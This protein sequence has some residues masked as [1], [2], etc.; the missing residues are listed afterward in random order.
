MQLS[1]TTRLAFAVAAL[2]TVL[3]ACGVNPVTG[4]KE[5]QFVSEASELQIGEKNYSPTR[6]G[7]GG[8]LTVLPELTTY[9]SGV[10]Q[11][12][13]AV[14]DRKLPY[15]F[16]VLNNSV[17]NAWALPGGKIAVNRGLLTELQ[18]EAELAAVLGHEIVHAAA[19][20]GAKAQE[21]GTMMQIGM[22]AAQVGAAVGG[23]DPGIANL[24]LGGASTGLQMIQMKYG[25]D[26]ELESDLYGMKYMKLAGYDP[27]G[28][29]TLQETFVRLSGAGGQKQQSWMEGLFASHPPSQERVEKNRKTAEELGRG[30]EVGAESYAAATK[31][32]RQMKPA[33]DKA[34]Q[35]VAAA[36]KKDFATAKSLASEAVKAIPNEGSFQ[37]L[38]GQIA[39]AEKQ[40]Q[41][42]AGHYEKAMALSPNFFGSYLGAGIAQVQLGDKPKAE[43]YLKRSAQ[44]LPT[45]PAAFYLGNIARDRGD[46]E[47]ARQ[48][49]QAAAGSQSS[50]GQAAAAEFVKMDLPQNP[51]QYVAAA[52]QFDGQGRLMVVVQNKSPAPLH[53][54]QV[55]PVLVDASG[56]I[57]QEGKPVVIPS[58]VKPGEQAAAPS[59]L[60]NIPAE[61]LQ[62]LR[63]RV[64]GAKIS[65]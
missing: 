65:E 24:A 34:D 12:L 35:A 18:N 26:Q 25:R 9:V 39:L 32:L 5:I 2:S 10:G 19:R 43:Q 37:V 29:V 31:Q 28:A 54:I 53:S 17:P 40:P 46:T 15:E 7:E 63:F 60:A 52:G 55:T 6:Q 57:V 22:A 50:I 16:V 44:L 20:H 30:G 1:K 59:G 58:V 49:Y 42:A 51:G 8:D 27:T 64:D 33:Y 21:R 3:C 45:A 48:Y 14:A 61:Q 38:L 23:V 41:A 47:A 11:K 56:R 36:Q 4:K 13:A 62:A